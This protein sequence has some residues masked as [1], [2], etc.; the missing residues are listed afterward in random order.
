MKEID[1][2]RSAKLL[3]EQYGTAAPV[4]AALRADAMLARGDLNGAAVWKRIATAIFTIQSTAGK[5]K[6]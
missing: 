6:H 1:I 4:Q 2:Y 3:V 5:T